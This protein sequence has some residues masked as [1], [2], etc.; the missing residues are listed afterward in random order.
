MV[1][2]GKVRRLLAL[3]LVALV[4]GNGTWWRDKPVVYDRNLDL[5][6]AKLDTPPVRETAPH[7]GPFMLEGIWELRS[8]VRRWGGF[9]TLLPPQD[10]RVAAYSD[11][12]ARLEFSLPGAPQ[13]APSFAT[14][15]KSRKMRPYFYD[16]EAA[17]RDPRSGKVWLSSEGRNAIARFTADGGFD[18]IAMPAEIQGWGI[19]SA[20]EAMAR[21]PDGRFILLREAFTGWFEDSEHPALIF[22]GD[23]V[24][25]AKARH[26]TVSGPV[27]FSP[28]EMARLPD[29]RY[30][31]LMRRFLWPLPARFAGRIAIGDPGEI[32]E[33]KTWR[34]HEL[35]RLT[36]TLPVDNFEG[37]GVEPRKDGKV[38]VWLMS[39]DNGAAYQRTLLWKL[40]VDPADLPGAPAK[41]GG[42]APRD[43]KP[44]D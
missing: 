28:T 38:N 43:S 13:A 11:K 21:L 26:F 19:N 39:D 16:I 31:V 23:P 8:G 44:A 32:R 33:G 30:L 34:L 24:E 40:V 6:I 9:S 20:A 41:A 7:L 14:I 4:L 15:Y 22:D 42:Q 27:N 3:A 1:Y 10:G 37:M 17:T 12:G 2:R 29:G 18:G 25:G 5:K 36:S 35:A